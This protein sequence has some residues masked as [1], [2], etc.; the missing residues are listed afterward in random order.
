MEKYTNM[1][2][3]LMIGILTVIS[4]PCECQH[5]PLLTACLWNPSVSGHEWLTEGN[6]WSETWFG[7]KRSPWTWRC[8]CLWCMCVCV[9]DP[10]LQLMVFTRILARAGTKSQV[11]VTVAGQDRKTGQWTGSTQRKKKSVNI[12]TNQKDSC[13]VT[14]WPYVT[15]GP[16]P[17]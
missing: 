11:W 2:L 16:F 10:A 14:S 6:Q 1:S 3:T 15:P 8:V 17:P 5:R 7:V 13:N 4:A 12:V 9:L